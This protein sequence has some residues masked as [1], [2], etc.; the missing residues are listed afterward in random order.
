MKEITDKL[1]NELL[2]KV[3]LLERWCDEKAKEGRP[4]K[5]DVDIDWITASCFAF[6]VKVHL[7]H[8]MQDMI[9]HPSYKPKEQED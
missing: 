4:R 1:A 7:W 2:E 3:V 5:G 8:H 9:S 6:D